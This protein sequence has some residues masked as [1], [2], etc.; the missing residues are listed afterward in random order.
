[1]RNGSQVGILNKLFRGVLPIPEGPKTA[2]RIAIT[3]PL[4]VKGRQKYIIT[5]SLFVNNPGLKA[6]A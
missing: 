2:T 3:Y 5:I 4:L 1:M 6:G